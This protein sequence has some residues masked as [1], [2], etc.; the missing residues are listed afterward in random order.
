M[1]I[2]IL[3]LARKGGTAKYGAWLTAALQPYGNL[4]YIRSSNSDY[5]VPGVTNHAIFTGAT[6]LQNI[7]ATCNPVSHIKLYN[8]IVA[9]NPDILIVP[10]YHDWLLPQLKHSKCPT[11]FVVHDPLPHNGDSKYRNQLQQL[12]I[13]ASSKPVVLS[14]IFLSTVPGAVMIPHGSF[15]LT[16]VPTKVPQ[17]KTLLFTGRMQQYQGLDLLIPAFKTSLLQHPDL[18]LIIAGKN[19]PDIKHPAIT[20]ISKWLTDQEQADLCV[21]ASIVVIPY[22]EATQSGVIALAQSLGRPVIATNVGGLPEQIEAGKTG[23][24]CEPNIQSLSNTIVKAV[25]QQESLNSMGYSGW[26]LYNTRFSWPTIAKQFI[27]ECQHILK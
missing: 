14:S 26:E 15:A 3:N 7:V 16:P 18:K 10:A 25:Q 6:S 19:A 4:T 24:I 11:I 20:C 21:Q 1:N 27:T 17:T 5:Q 9:S 8:F 22:T 12:C 13:K 23:W 2:T